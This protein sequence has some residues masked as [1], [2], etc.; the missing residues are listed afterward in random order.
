V[1][2]TVYLASFSV[3]GGIALLWWSLGAG[4]RSA[5]IVRANLKM[6]SFR[7][8]LSPDRDVVARNV[9]SIAGRL[10]G[11]LSLA[12]LER[13]LAASHSSRRWTAERLFLIKVT[14]GAAV[15]IFGIS[16]AFAGSAPSHVLL[17]VAGAVVAFFVP[18]IHLAGK[19]KDRAKEVELQLPDLLD[20]LTVTVEA[21][22][23]FDSALSHV[24]DAGEG[25]VYD[26]FRHVLQDIRLG[27]PRDR[28]IKAL[29]DR[30]ASA[31]LRQFASAL[32][33][34]SSYGLPLASVMRS[35]SA[36]LREKRRFRA[37]ERALKIPV[38][39]VFPLV[40]CILPTIFIV[41]LAPALINIK[42][43][44]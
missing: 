10:P 25:P 17:Y 13:R 34:A 44:L 39:I 30:T 29:T 27:V 35:Q 15:L 20:R 26:E 8:N 9:Q 43:I 1:P 6:P 12:G 21:G 40:I 31:D 22:L 18:D 11:A 2:V 37:E 14:L 33:Q 41:L 23:G 3:I 36:D 38:K 24:I 7:A 4:R 5:E 19:A 28:A 16:R 32:N 42:T